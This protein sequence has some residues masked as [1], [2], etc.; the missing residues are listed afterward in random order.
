MQLGNPSLV[1]EYQYIPFFTKTG[2]LKIM[3]KIKETKVFNL[4]HKIR[5]TSITKTSNVVNPSLY[6]TTPGVPG[7]KP[8]GDSM[9]SLDFYSYEVDQ[10]STRQSWKLGGLK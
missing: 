4:H 9:V 8:I 1:T 7:S 10:M 6:I 3:H 5:F 2:S